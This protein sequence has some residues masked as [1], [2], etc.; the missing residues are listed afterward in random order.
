MVS[1]NE[2]TLPDIK[3]LQAV[4]DINKQPD[5]YQGTDR[6]KYPANSR[7]IRQATD[8]NSNQISY[9]MGGNSSS[10]GFSE[11][12]NPLIISYQPV[13]IDNGF[14]PRSAE[15]TD[16]GEE[17]LEKSQ[18]QINEIAGIKRQEFNRLQSDFEEVKQ[19]VQSQNA[20]L[21]AIFDFDPAE[22]DRDDETVANCGSYIL[23]RLN[24][25][26]EKWDR[27]QQQ[28]QQQQQ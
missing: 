16:E 13:I 23:A 28:R 18:N 4:R 10:R 21:T 7:S 5:N 14:G 22:V 9:R 26:S 27:I 8:L 24:E 17:M 2:L 3:F 20:L 19:T 25:L 6:S 15:L 11:G 1:S 12:D